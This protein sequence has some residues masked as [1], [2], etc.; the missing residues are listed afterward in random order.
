MPLSETTS[1]GSYEVPETFLN[2]D[3][4]ASGPVVPKKKH[5]F[6][7]FP[8]QKK[9][10]SPQTSPHLPTGLAEP[11]EPSVADSE[12]TFEQ[13]ENLTTLPRRDSWGNLT[14]V[15][16]RGTPQ[17][18]TA[19]RN[20]RTGERNSRGEERT[21]RVENRRSHS[22]SPEDQLGEKETETVDSSI[23]Q[24]ARQKRFAKLLTSLYTLSYLT[25]FSILGTLARV[26]IEALTLYPGAPITTPV[27]WANFAGSLFMGFLAEDRKLFLEEWGE[28]HK[29]REQHIEWLKERRQQRRMER[30]RQRRERELLQH[31]HRYSN[32]MPAPRPFTNPNT[33]RLY[34]T[35]RIFS[36]Q[37]C[38]SGPFF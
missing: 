19:N 12:A 16:E 31:S 1:E 10:G 34:P 30:A 6:I 8:D 22:P 14:T 20:S 23:W 5:G 35:M 18:G 9:R 29:A 3:E 11:T 15:T 25:F 13:A 28:K 7:F 32:T 4:V 21:S 2:L 37:V 27:I 17:P 26:G 24:S 38:S 36:S 33:A